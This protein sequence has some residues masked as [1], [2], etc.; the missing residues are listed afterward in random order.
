MVSCQFGD[1]IQAF[2]NIGNFKLDYHVYTLSL[3]KEAMARDRNAPDI[4]S[5][6]IGPASKYVKLDGRTGEGG[7]QVVR[8]ASCLAALTGV[9]LKIENV[10]G[11]R[12]GKNRGGNL[13]TG[14]FYSPSKS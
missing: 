7:G 3:A 6:G 4:L 10:R 9:A 8:I 2:R 12:P 1:I 13:H 11:N 14:L 5:K